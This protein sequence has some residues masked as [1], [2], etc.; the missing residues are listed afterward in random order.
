MSEAV[1]DLLALM[2]RLSAPK[3][4]LIG[5][6]MGGRLALHLALAAPERFWALV[7]ESASPGI[8]DPAEREARR[9]SD[10][11]LAEAIERDGVA[12][13]VA[14]WESQPLFASQARLP[15]GVRASLRQ[16]RL[17]NRPVGLANSLRG[18]GA[19]VQTPVWDR[20]P[21]IGMPAL[22]LAGEHDGKYRA[23]AERTAALLP[24]GRLEVVPGAGHAIHLE[25]PDA[26][27]QVVGSFLHECL[28]LDQ[29]S[30]VTLCP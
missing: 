18:M 23:I 14:R 7:L 27:A 13:F 10:E 6:S 5:Y 16:Q 30:E 4:G 1:E 29:R 15:A 22:V 3:A 25:R 26:F 12:A 9:Q 2:D 24:G 28:R 8:E 19:G 20:L 11:A 21:E 17:R